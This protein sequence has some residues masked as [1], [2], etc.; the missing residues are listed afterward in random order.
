MHN[1]ISTHSALNTSGSECMAKA[2]M[3][4]LSAVAFAT[5]GLLSGSVGS[6]IAWLALLTGLSFLFRKNPREVRI[7]QLAFTLTSLAGLIIIFDNVGNFGTPFSRGHDDSEYFYNILARL[8]GNS[9]DFESYGF[10]Y[11]NV[12]YGYIVSLLTFRAPS[13]LTLFDVLPLNWAAVGICAVYVDRIVARV[14]DRQAPLWV[15]LVPILGNHNFMGSVSRFYRDTYVV[16]FVAVIVELTLR[17]RYGYALGATACLGLIRGGNGIL[18]VVFLAVAFMINE[19]RLS[20]VKRNYAL[21]L[22]VLAV[23]YFGGLRERG[24]VLYAVTSRVAGDGAKYIRA[25]EGEDYDVI[26]RRRLVNKARRSGNEQRERFVEDG[27]I[28]GAAYKAG[29]SLFFPITFYGPNM[30]QESNALDADSTYAVRGF[31]LYNVVKWVYVLAWILVVPNLVI[32]VY[33]GLSQN[34]QIVN[35]ICFYLLTVVAVSQISFQVRH[36]V[37]FVV[38]HPILVAIGYNSARERPGISRRTLAI[39]TVFVIVGY[40]FYKFG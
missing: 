38:L 40:N 19:G 23:A 5:F 18:A 7:V 2:V 25:F 37:A 32:G 22:G 12:A 39:V 17:R 11:L 10:Q 8:E 14:I 26:I 33:V 16:L 9:Y 1:P 31:F 3:V 30:A 6:S 28:P 29:Y 24:N 15:V 27:G 34:K 13:S 35:L 4:F 20:H 36:T 21:V